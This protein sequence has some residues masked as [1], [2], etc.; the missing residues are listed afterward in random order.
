MCTGNIDMTAH[1]RYFNELGVLKCQFKDSNTS[2]DRCSNHSAM[3]RMHYLLRAMDLPQIRKTT[4]PFNFNLLPGAL[5]TNIC[6]DGY[7]I[8][9]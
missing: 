7:R 1:T 5:R 8:S 2:I 4:C 3:H 6:N 9:R